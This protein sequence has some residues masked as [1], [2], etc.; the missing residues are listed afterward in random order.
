MEASEYHST[1]AALHGEAVRQ[2]LYFQH[3]TDE[4]LH[5]RSININGENLVSFASCSYLGLEH[6][7][8]LIA[9]VIDAVQRFGTQFSASRA[10]VSA[11]PYLELEDLLSRIFGGYTLVTS[12][13][14]LGHQIALGVLATEKDAIILDHQVHYSVQM[15]SRLARTSGA[16][17]ETVRHGDLDDALELVKKLARTHRTVWFAVDGVY[18][19][20]GDLAPVGLLRRVLEVSPNVRLY[21]D[22][23]HGMS[24]AGLN[25]QGSFLSRMPMSDR[26]VLA[27]SL[28]KAFAAGGG[29]IVFPTEEERERVRVIGGPL[30]FSGPL[31]PPMLGA[32]VASARLHL[33]DE[34]VSYQQRLRERVDLCNRLIREAELPLLVENESP[35]FFLRVGEFRHAFEVARRMKKEGMYVTPSAYPT[36]PIQRAGIRLSLT[37]AHELDDV[38]RVVM[39]L[40]E[41]LP[42]VLEEEGVTRSRLDELFKR[43][44][45]TETRQLQRARSLLSP[46]QTI[47][48][49]SGV[50]ERHVPEQITIAPLANEE[51]HTQLTI[52]QYGS[53]TQI[54]K[55]LWDSLF[56]TVG[57]CSWDGMLL[58]ET[59]FSGQLRPEHNWEFLYVIVRDESDRVVAA[60]F[61]TTALCKDDMLMREE[62][63]RA[64]EGR[65]QDNPYFLTSSVM[66]MGSQLSEGVH[67]FL[68]RQ[69]AWRKALTHTLE[70]AQEA[71]QRTQAAVLMLRDLPA[72]DPEMDEFLLYNGLLKVPML[73]SHILHLNW[74]DQDE[75][76]ASLSRGKRK[77][78][79]ERA[80]QAKHFE[81]RVTGVSD[82]DATKLS[83][84]DISHLHSLYQQVATKGLRLNV[85]KLPESLLTEMLESSAWEVV[86]L[87][88]NPED[89]GPA[90]RQPVAFYAAHKFNG[91][92]TPFYCGLDYDYVHSHGVYRQVLYQTV[93]RALEL[94]MKAVHLGMSA[95]VEKSRFG[96][97]VVNNCVYVQAQDHYNAHLLQEIAAEVSVSA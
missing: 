27:T 24:W 83:E 80:K 19:M 51:D 89:G 38:A 70:V 84:S 21:V 74:N 29:C 1:V 41:H 3:A 31:Q 9:G 71:R 67:L 97:T 6:H 52:E 94:G 76:V 54:D 63:S 37:S 45:P 13:T 48:A 14:T 57:T 66:M 88:L 75:Y 95:D 20:Y 87:T 5:G 36:V 79:Q 47:A 91:H 39:G 34:I 50:D 35:I 15:A 7:P 44:L 96:T 64:V 23:A 8:A 69:R 28:N 73:D 11:P 68:D 59:V 40:A 62:V 16:R 26:I 55:Q 18:S 32:G 25:G 42:S 85:F 77:Q 17:V 33:S 90:N 30:A 56:G 12:S 72:D 86:T 49:L 93:L 81:R 10:Y 43:A 78:M 60:T 82:G 65:R 4:V 2:G 92:Y 46:S 58:Q 53:I 22:D 61:F